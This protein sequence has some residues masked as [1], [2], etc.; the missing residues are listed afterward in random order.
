MGERDDGCAGASVE[1]RDPLARLP[2][3]GHVLALMRVGAGEDEGTQP[4]PPQVFPQFFNAFVN[5]ICSVTHFVFSV[6]HA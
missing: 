6:I 2:M 1:A 5:A 3:F 4:V